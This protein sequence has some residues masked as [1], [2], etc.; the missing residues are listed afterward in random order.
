VEWS[1]VEE[2]RGTYLWLIVLV[3]FFMLYG[4]Y[5][6][7]VYPFKNQ[8]PSA[9]QEPSEATRCITPGFQLG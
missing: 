9:L 3:N 7:G 4:L 8:P 5:T 6:W 2:R 1:G